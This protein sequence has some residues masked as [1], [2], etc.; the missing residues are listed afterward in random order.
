MD[1]L[2]QR[3]SAFANIATGKYNY[4]G[5]WNGKWGATLGC[6]KCRKSMYD[7]K[8]FMEFGPA[9]GQSLYYC[10]TC[11]CEFTKLM[12]EAAEAKYN[13]GMEM[14]LAPG[15]EM[16]KMIIDLFKHKRGENARAANW[17]WLG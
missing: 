16:D 17:E 5:L 15:R 11:R 6:I 13:E 9:R 1:T 2:A 8:D 7:F 3:I 14:L 4:F 10:E 12:V